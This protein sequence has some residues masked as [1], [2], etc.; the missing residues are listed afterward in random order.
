M[1]LKIKPLNKVAKS[2]YQNHGHFHD[3]DAGLDLYIIENQTFNP[4]ET[5]LIKLGVSCSL[6]AEKHTI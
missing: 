5:K 4:G 6:K 1:K 2:F 3:G